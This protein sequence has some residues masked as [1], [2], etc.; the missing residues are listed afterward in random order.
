MTDSN[1]D[2]L[3]FQPPAVPRIPVTGQTTK[4]PVRRIFCVGRN[5][6]EHAKEMGADP[7]RDPPFFFTKPADAIVVNGADIPYPSA[8]KNLHHEVEL[9]IAIAQG[10]SDIPT[11]SALDHVYGY[12]VGND[13]TRRDLQ[14]EAKK[15][16]RPWDTAKGFD[17]S[18]PISS[19]SPVSLCGHI[20]M[21]KIYLEVNGEV[22]Q[23]GDISDMIWSVAEIIS[24]LSSL[25]ALQPGDLIFSG[26]PAGVG[27]LEPGDRVHAV[28]AGLPP[29]AHTIKTNAA[30]HSLVD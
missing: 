14:A 9:V 27:P 13:L 29:L 7:E 8:T 24:A 11:H 30:M 17:Q 25:F 26:T 20:N 19:I 6:A 23:L 22:R 28:V 21:G 1:T 18:A 10:G 16:G 3:V 12:A 4:F 2:S 5:Y 15:S